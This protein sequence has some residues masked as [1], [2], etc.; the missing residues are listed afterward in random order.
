[1]FVAAV[2]LVAGG[3]SIFR[4][5]PEIAAGGLLYPQ[6]HLLA[7]ARPAN[8]DAARFNGEGVVLV[9]WKC[10]PAGKPRG[11]VVYLHGVADNR[12]SAA[13]AITRFTADGYDVIAYDSRAHGESEGQICTYGFFEKDDLRHVLDGVTH[14]PIV[15]MGTSL[16]AAVAV[17]E[18]AVDPRVDGVIAAEVFSD[19]R[20]VATE[21]APRMLSAGMIAKAF[22]RA[23][24]RG[25]FRVDEVSPVRAAAHIRVPVF[26]IHGAADLDTPP[27]HSRRVFAALKEPKRLMLVEGAHHNESL[28]REDVWGA[29][30]DWLRLTFPK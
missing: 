1:L 5:L 20:A 28:N 22:V 14:H 4:Q 3:I 19:L 21:R 16:G 11:T 23:E 9:G 26:L 13:G 15:L 25:H 30:E 27:D 2:V 7:A 24:E 10:H 8:C 18:A 12:G 29:I 6:R 17:Q